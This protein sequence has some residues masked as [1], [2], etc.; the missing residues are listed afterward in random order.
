M[1]SHPFPDYVYQRL[2]DHLRSWPQRAAQEICMMV[3][4]IS[5]DEDDEWRGNMNFSA[6]TAVFWAGTFIPNE[7]EPGKK[8]YTVMVS[9][10]EHFEMCRGSGKWYGSDDPGDTEC[11]VL[12]DDHFRSLNLAD[13]EPGAPAAAF[14]DVCADSIQR[15]FQNGVITE[16][17]GQ[18]VPVILCFG[19]DMGNENHLMRRMREANP[20]SLTDEYYQWR[21]EHF[22][23]AEKWD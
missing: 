16:V 23:G 19:N 9:P 5:F 13:R 15:L 1:S 11:V 12:R 22:S 17:C 6:T 10:F 18:P 14:V 21:K 3:C 2:A 7:Q 8:W 4:M 20:P